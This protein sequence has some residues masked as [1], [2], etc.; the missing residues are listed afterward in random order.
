MR[1]AQ[2]RYLLVRA[3]ALVPC[4]LATAALVALGVSEAGFNPSAWYPAT[5]FVLGLLAVTLIALGPPRGLPRLLIAALAL[6]AAYTLW[7]YLSIAW[8]EQQGAA[9][10]G[11]NRTALYLCLFALFCLWPIDA[12]GGRIVLGTLGLGIAGAG[13]VELLRIDS[14][15]DPAGYIVEGRVVEPAGYVNAN[16]ALWTVGLL[17]CLPPAAGRDVPAVLRGLALGGAGLLGALA[18]LAQSRGWLLALPLG[19]LAFVL[20]SPGRLR[21]LL[22]VLATGA[23]MAAAL[24]PLLAVHDDFS[25]AGL[26]ELVADAARASWLMAGALTVLGFAGALLDRR[27]SSGFRARPRRP[28]PRPAVMGIAVAVVVAAAIGLVAADA[29]GRASD[30]WDDFKEGGQPEAG[31][32]RFSSIGTYRY[33]FWRVAWDEF[34]DNPV[35]GIGV[36]N[37]QASY[38]RRGESFEKPRYAHSLELGVLSQTGLVGGVLL[39]GALGAAL[40]AAA[41]RLTRAGPLRWVSAGG[42]AVFAYW[43]AHASVDWLWEFPALGGAAFMAL[44]L[45]VAPAA[46]PEAD[47]ASVR[48]PLGVAAT[49]GVFACCLPLAVAVGAPWLSERQI[50]RALADWRA[51]PGTAL[52]RLDRAADLNPLSPRAQLTAG[53]IAVN[54]DALD[55]AADRF[56]AALRREPDNSYALL[57]L[58]VIASER[59]RPDAAERYLERA[60]ELAPRDEIIE[61]ALEEVRAGRL[62]RLADVNSAILDRANARRQPAP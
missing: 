39:F 44:G 55:V 31:G 16:A 9:L 27:I 52:N 43:F 19:V 59:G 42:L 22:V 12:A 32:S 1:L 57:E 15:A 58:G 53:T 10:E 47:A 33:D 37:F 20:I 26:D 21:A 6:F 61:G 46:A 48:R 62:V 17:A 14:A 23:G 24:G 60:L 13:A 51:S 28:G 34:A 5:L 36:E 35:A 40:V 45:A 41:R 49:V 25:G 3:P 18:L 50:Q 11:A 7:T 8:A 54:I 29:P 30:A 56:R 38:L 2:A 4:L